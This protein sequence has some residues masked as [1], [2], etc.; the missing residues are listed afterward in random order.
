MEKRNRIKRVSAQSIRKITVL[1]IL[2]AEFV[3]LSKDFSYS[4]YSGMYS[5]D[6]Y[7]F[8]CIHWD[9]QA[10]FAVNDL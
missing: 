5:I 4:L 10:F 2:C 9:Y 6:I 3:K 8:I 7:V 1:R